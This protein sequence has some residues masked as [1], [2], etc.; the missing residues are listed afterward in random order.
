M[1]LNIKNNHVHDLAKEAARLTGLSQTSVI[2]VALERYLAD[3]VRP[4]ATQRRTR[5]LEI[6]A[7]VDRRLTDADRAAMTTD[8]LYDEAGLPR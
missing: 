4:D 3:V 2:E 6:L 5:V 7:D 8:D 1:A